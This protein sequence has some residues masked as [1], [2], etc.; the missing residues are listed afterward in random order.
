ME[1]LKPDY[2]DSYTS[3]NNIVITA[4]Y[5]FAKIPNIELFRDKAIDVCKRNN[6][7]GTI[8]LGHEGVNGTISGERHGIDAFYQFIKQYIELDGIVFKESLY[9]KYP[10]EKLKIKLKNEIVT[11]KEECE[12]N[13]G[14]YVEPSKWDEFISQKDVVVV[15]T[16]N[17]YEFHI[18]TFAGSINPE[19]DNFT[20]FKEWCFRNIP[21]KNTPIAGFCTGGIRCEK[22]TSWLKKHGYN[23]VYH[24]KGGIIGYFIETKNSNKMWKG[25]CFVFDDR[26]IINDKL[27]SR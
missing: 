21:D 14:T 2:C 4:F 18:G 26:V 19:T 7:L 16:R 15:D 3:G 25:D 9:K 8:L 1:I 22:S 17:D 20:E 10:F 11:I 12:F 23:N 5:K 27:E 6:I 24:L 13:P